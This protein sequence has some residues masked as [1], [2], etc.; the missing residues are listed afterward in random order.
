MKQIVFFILVCV[1][2]VSGNTGSRAIDHAPLGVMGD[3]LHKKGEWM[4]S[5]RY[6]EMRMKDNF[7]NGQNASMI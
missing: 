3:H 6:I 2:S 5:F 1:I 4:F 7:I